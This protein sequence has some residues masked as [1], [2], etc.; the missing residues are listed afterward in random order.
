MAFSITKEE[1][2]HKGYV[3]FN[4]N[5]RKIGNNTLVVAEHGQWAILDDGEFDLLENGI[6]KNDSE[7]FK[8][9]EEKGII[10]TLKN[11]NLITD[12]Y[13]QRMSFLNQGVSLHIVVLT[14]KCT[15]KCVYCHASAK[16]ASSSEYDMDKE[17]A[18]KTVDFIFQSPSQ[19]ITIEFQGGEPLLNFD[20]LKF[21]TD[22]SKEK[23]KVA[24]KD[25]RLALV[26]NLEP[27]DEEKLN[28]LMENDVSICTSLDGPEELHN[29]NRIAE[30]KEFNSH[31]NV[32]EW[33]SK[34]RK[35]CEDE[36]KNWT[37][38]ALM[39]T[40]KESLKYP[41]EIVDEFVK[42]KFRNIY[43][44]PLNGLGF[45]NDNL[46]KVGYS[47]EE[48]INFWKK[49]ADYIIELNSKGIFIKESMIGIMLTK[50]LGKRDANHVDLRSP[51]G[52]CI[53]QL[54]YNHDGNIFS[55]DEART[56][57]E[58]VFMIGNVDEKYSDVV[59]CDKSCTIVSSSIIDSNAC[60]E[61]AWKPFCGTCPVVTFSET[62][63]LIP[64]IPED[65]RC[66]IH[67][68]QFQYIFE[69]IQDDD[70]QKVIK[71]WFSLGS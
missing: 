45:S 7:L 31:K 36:K 46:K 33:A 49:C 21:I 15:H 4:Y 39:T 13:K 20:I 42:N 37:I 63:S 66:R 25:L 2:E 11:E 23:N 55:C 61:C 14:R 22:Y 38:S 27:M 24:K 67:D 62:N 10:L 32:V 34:I 12:Y 58:D 29:K 70:F 54:A 50:I 64:I 5:I 52:A 18:K 41:K 59:A 9:L 60:A 71:R 68:A 17:T 44:R 69:K 43:V 26:T 28:F 3:P 6:I 16:N 35:R 57:K 47:A 30:K 48:F 40:T 56:L 65:S 53:S 19:C 51:C 1:L 8:M